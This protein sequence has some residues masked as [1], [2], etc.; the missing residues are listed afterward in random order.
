MNMRQRGFIALFLN[1]PVAANLLMALMILGGIVG[2]LKMNVQFLPNF[3]INIVS[4]EIPWPGAS[5]DDVEK[6]IVYPLEKELRRVDNVKNLQVTA[7]Q[8]SALFIVEFI[9][10]VDLSKAS[11]QV[12]D[13]VSRVRTFPKDS[14]KPIIERIEPDERVASILLWGPKN[15]DELRVIAYQAERELLN[16][17]ISK[18][19][20]IGLPKK[21]IHIEFTLKKLN[22]LQQSLPDLAQAIARESQDVPAGLLNRAQSGQNLRA[23]EKKRSIKAFEQMRIKTENPVESVQL[24]HIAHIQESISENEPRL[25]FNQ[26]PAVELRLYRSNQDSA[27][28]AAK[29]A[30][31]WIDSAK[32]RW[33]NSIQIDIFNESWI[34]IKERIDTLIW[35]GAGGLL[36]I[37]ILLFMFLNR[38]VAFWVSVGIPVSLLAAMFVLYLNNDSINMVSLFAFILT[39]GIIVDD[40]IVVGE[41]TLTN[42]SMKED[43]HQSVLN[44]CYK[45]LPA[46]SA[47]SLTT[48]AAFLPLMV[49][50]GVIGN[51]LFTIPL[52]VICVI[53]ASMVECFFVLPSHLFHSLINPDNR[54]ISTFRNIFDLKIERIR[55]LWFKPLVKKALIY[56]PVVMLGTMSML[57]LVTIII[58]FGYVKFSFFPTPDGNIIRANVQFVS[59][60]PESKRLSWLN[61]IEQTGIRV[62]NDM[63][64]SEGIKKPVIIHYITLNRNDVDEFR[65]NMGEQFSSITLELI[66][67]DKRQFTNQ[68]VMSQW[69]AL[70][71][72]SDFIESVAITAPRGGPPGKDIDIEVSGLDIQNIKTALQRIREALLKI[73]GVNG[74]ED[75]LPLSQEQIVFKLSPLG[76]SLGIGIDDIGRQ[77]RAAINGELLQTYNTPD[78]EIEVRILLDKKTRESPD[79][80]SQ[81]LVKAPKGAMR[82]LPE[83]IDIGYKALPE[84]IIHNDYQLSANILAQVDSYMANTNQILSAL[85]ETLLPTLAKELNLSFKF[86]GRAEDQQQTLHDI[87]IG[88]FTALFLMYIILAWVFSSYSKPLI[89]MAA[90]PLGLIGA[91]LGHLIMGLDVTLLSIFGFFGLSGIVINDSIILI[92]EYQQ[93]RLER[94]RVVAAISEAATRR[95]RAIFL[96]SITTIAGLTPL[97]FER[98]LQAQ[99]L[100]PMA[101]SISFGLAFAT[102]LLLLVIPVLLLYVENVTRYFTAHI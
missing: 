66:S 95:L 12:R 2:L 35:N 86:K 54:K 7:R 24:S 27:L 39:L 101:C 33:G 44:A 46:I 71:K 29:I 65:A 77:L 38:S 53:I 100:I 6:G 59:G 32:Q 81:L 67:N 21:E 68:E 91:L 57:L 98:S 18:T 93:L 64:Q 13:A 16:K 52:V 89:V 84:V 4:V 40:T 48:I 11:E 87:R 56:H 41:Q 80:L 83:I 1:N 92:N 15:L 96:T 30:H 25:Y 49:V 37:I 42:L 23:I 22:E 85:Q 69:Q 88:I 26:K 70:I 62:I 76:E 79:V 51:V 99:F 60:T 5:A 8:N 55:R 20:I 82:P 61:K 19:R 94:M 97:L 58:S 43:A 75:N 47:S 78:E 73:K 17:G 63:G 72:A 28:K 10:G 74:I 9:E 50:G 45:M 36:L 31:D 34:L 14:E 3:D 102:I 90:I